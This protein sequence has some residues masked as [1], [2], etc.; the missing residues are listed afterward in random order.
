MGDLNTSVAQNVVRPEYG[1][2]PVSGK[3]LPKFKLIS[4][5][6]VIGMSYLV[7]C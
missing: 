1:S 3:C 6:K 4:C 2:S 5:E 7:S